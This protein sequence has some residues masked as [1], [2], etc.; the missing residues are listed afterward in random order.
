[1]LSGTKSISRSESAPIGVR[2]QL[3]SVFLFSVFTNILMLTGPLFMLQVYDRV[4]SSGSEETLVALTGLVIILYGLFGILEYARGRIAARIGARFHD[5]LGVQVFR[6]T[7]NGSNSLP[8]N[9]T[10]QLHDLEAIRTFWTSPVCLVFFDLPWTPVFA[11]AIFVFHPLLGWLALGGGTI[12]LLATLIN[13]WLTSKNALNA[14]RFAFQAQQFAAQSRQCSDVIQAQGMV[15]AISKKWA[16]LQHKA[17][18][19]T[20]TANDGTGA[21]TAFSKSFRFLLQSGMLAVGAWLVL[22][23][24]LTAGAMIAGSILMGRALA[25]VEQGLAQWHVAQRAWAGYRA[26]RHLSLNQPTKSQL[27]KLPRPSSCISVHNL[28]FSPSG[29]TTPI[30]DDLSFDIPAGTALGVIGRSGSGKT[31]LARALVGLEQPLLGAI[32]LGGATL[33]QYGTNQLGQFVGYLPQNVRIFQGSIAQNI[34]QMDEAATMDQIITA[35]RQAHV[36]NMILDLPDGYATE[37]DPQQ[38]QLSG[39]GLQRLALARALFRDPVL[40]VLDEPNSALDAEG[41]AALNKVVQNMKQRG[42]TVVVMTHRPTAIH[43]CDTLMVLHHGTISG[44]GPRDQIIRTM[45]QNA[46]GV[47]PL[48]AHGTAS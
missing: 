18:M 26:V 9:K 8:H 19:A 25:P 33:S 32:R 3:I 29:A 13:Q 16:S 36:H 43:A 42:K 23:G 10:A 46:D 5:A 28:S 22:Q 40:L 47:H 39:G 44:L 45:V 20:L 4:L 21:L 17:A 48:T 41:S 6:T 11:I 30:L 14:Q 31:T 34:A 24:E 37:L 2:R 12:L 1:M 35:A 15:G 7:L 27:P 38:P